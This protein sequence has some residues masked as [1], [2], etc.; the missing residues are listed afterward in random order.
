MKKYL[1]ALMLLFTLL[2]GSCQTVEQ[3]S[4][5]YLLPADV[6]FPLELKRVAIVN[7]TCAT[8]DN[9]LVP[10]ES[11]VF[12][13]VRRAIAYHDGKAKIATESLA[14]AIADENF[15]DEVIIC[16]SAL[17]AN[18][19][20]PRQSTL[21]KQE[22][23]ELIAAL[24]V[25]FLIS[26]ENLQLKATKEVTFLPQWNSYLGTINVK[27]YPS[28]KVYIPQRNTPM[29]AIN[30]IDSIYWEGYNSR[31]ALALT[32]LISDKELLDQA[33]AF[34]GTVPVK[35]LIPYWKTGTRY[36]Y[37]NGSVA[38]RD[39]AVYVRQN[40]WEKAF[41][42]WNQAYNGA[43]SKKKQMQ[44][45]INIGLYYEMIDN[46]EEAEAWIVKAQGLAYT[47]EKVESMDLSQIE[48]NRIPN[49]FLTAIYLKELRE[50]KEGLA[51]LKMQMS[52]IT[53]DF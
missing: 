4:I 5:D 48:S 14:K 29:V 53:D 41:D 30:A 10:E 37:T 34:A 13:G 22:V 31:E 32:N 17:R 6:S 38:M 49:Y 47:L 7:N 40:S 44:T 16:D 19:I 27:A 26:L 1:C 11:K 36:Y 35:Y 2:L 20:L 39:A 50:R 8:P 45:A 28:I 9:K 3:L 25:D 12:D 21:S 51:K 18:D 52:R 43:K 24:D 23:E 15:F 46:M 33:S 42:L